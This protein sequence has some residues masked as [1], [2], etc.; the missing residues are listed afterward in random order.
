MHRRIAPLFLAVLVA[1]PVVVPASAA[2]PL[3]PPAAEPATTPPPA[4]DPT[5]ADQ[6]SPVPVAVGRA[7]PAAGRRSRPRRRPHPADPDRRAGRPSDG[8]RDPR[9]DRPLHRHAP[10]RERH[11][12]R[13]VPG[14]APRPCQGRPD[15]HPQRAR[16]FREAGSRP[17][18]R[19][20]GRPERPRHRPRRR[21]PA[22]PDR[23]DRRRPGR[24]PAERHRGDRR[25][26]P[27]RR[28]GRGDRRYRDLLPPR[29]QR[30]GRLQLLDRR[31]R[32][33]A[34]PQQPRD[35][36]GRHDRRARQ[37]HRRRGCR[38]GRPGVGRQDPQRRR[39]R[40]HLVVHL[41]PRLDPRPARSGR[42]QP[43]ALRGGQHE[44][45]EARLR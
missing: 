33:L 23:P 8:T 38:T 41:R 3:A 17:A 36:R 11:R 37:R 43:A 42:C 1:L 39:L 35:A 6:P 34:R 26:G 29:S 16:L 27:P 30:R 28:R 12:G 32:G 19:A 7:D 15:V 9:R 21:R 31:P 40:P 13:R 44:R 18:R 45:H 25:D 24:W 4:P 10:Q 20:P 5:P 22:D 2:E 14:S